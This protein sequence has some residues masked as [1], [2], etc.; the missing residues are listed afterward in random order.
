MGTKGTINCNPELTLRQAG[1]PMVLPLLEE[2]VTPFILH[3]LGRTLEE[4]PS[5]LEKD[6]PKGTRV[7]T[8]ELRSLVQLQ[9]LATI[10]SRVHFLD[11]R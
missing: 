11:V 3:G 6:H 4:D 10:Q 7:G 9:V 5:S 1:Y 8:T 2:E